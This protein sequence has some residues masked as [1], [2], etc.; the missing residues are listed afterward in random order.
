[1]F[2]MNNISIIGKFLTIVS[3]FA[4]FILCVVA[5][6]SLKISSVDSGYSD[7]LEHE[8]IA[9]Q[10]LLQ[11]NRAF[12]TARS[13][14]GELTVSRFDQQKKHTMD[15][16]STSRKT[17]V[18]AFDA[19]ISALPADERFSVLKAKVIDVLDVNCK[20]TINAAAAATNESDIKTSQN[21]F[22]SDCQPLFPALTQE[23]ADLS[24]E[25]MGKVQ[26]ISDQ[27]STVSSNTIWA[28]ASGSV[29]GLIIV[30][31]SA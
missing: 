18:S 3:A 7:L 17:L 2:A 29:L 26:A 10:K 4:L 27:L 24:N 5:Y 28:T 8:V 25:T 13:D 16:L 9:A 15:D 20:S 22:L 11:A 30:M 19:A 1:M 31:V 12:Q 6:S 14:M 21:I 23:I